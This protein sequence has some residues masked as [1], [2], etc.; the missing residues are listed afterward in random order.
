MLRVIAL[1]RLRVHTGE[2]GCTYVALLH[3]RC[4]DWVTVGGDGGHERE[5]GMMPMP[6]LHPRLL[7]N[8]Q[9][10][11]PFSFCHWLAVLTKSHV[12]L[13]G[14]NEIKAMLLS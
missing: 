13:A 10:G 9:Q 5:E 6:L 4:S 12:V 11:L 2:L 1:T 7:S 8:K 14:T 3:R